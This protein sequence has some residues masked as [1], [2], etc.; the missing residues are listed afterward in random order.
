MTWSVSCACATACVI[1]LRL[2]TIWQVWTLAYLMC[3]ARLT[4]QRMQHVPLALTL[5]SGMVSR[6]LMLGRG[7]AALP[8]KIT[9]KVSYPIEGFLQEGQLLSGFVGQFGIADIVGYHVCRPDE[10]H[11]D[12]QR[13]F[14][15]EVQ[16]FGMSLAVRVVDLKRGPNNPPRCPLG[17]GVS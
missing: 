6:T 2:Y 13:L 3:T 1:V 17:D 10:P 14:S 5:L 12:T 7:T 11:D 16:N 15:S 8:D 4:W 9:Y